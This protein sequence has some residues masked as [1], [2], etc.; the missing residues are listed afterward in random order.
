MST[1]VVY[2]DTSDGS[3]ESKHASSVATA[4]AGNL[5]S[6]TATAYTVIGQFNDLGETGYYYVWEAFLSFDTS[7]IGTDAVSAAVLSVTSDIS[8]NSETDFAI[9]ARL[10]DWG[11]TL[12][13]ADWVAGASLSGLT[14]LGSYPTASG[15]VPGTTYDLS[16]TAMAANVNKTGSTRMLL[17]SS[18]HVAASAPATD[19]VYI[20]PADYT[21][22]TSDPKLTVTYAAGAT[23][24][25]WTTPADTVSMTTT[26]ELKFTSPAS[27]VAQHFY[28]QLDTANTFDSGNL[29]TLDSSTSQTSWD[30]W[31]GAAW[32][33][34]PSTGLASGYA[35]NEIRYT[36]TSALSS[37]TWYR[38]VRAGTLA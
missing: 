24:P 15:F 28:L 13:T 23:G 6:V 38:R 34:L 8:D 20:R 33:A 9:E 25:A 37:A 29:R 16:D 1:L 32:A 31:T 4:Q 22:T 10:R 11:T 14:L 35:G 5:L 18:R 12:T 17:D 19:H 27:A 3:L 26:P 7:A 36:V 21:G 2:S 30:Y